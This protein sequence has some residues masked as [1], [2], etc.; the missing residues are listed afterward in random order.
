MLAQK[1][2]QSAHTER[3]TER[4][5]FYL[6]KRQHSPKT[7]G[8]E[9]NSEEYHRNLDNGV[10]EDVANFA[11][12]DIEDGLL[13]GLLWLEVV[14]NDAAETSILLCSLASLI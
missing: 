2:R 1:Y 8:K 10:G 9:D 14:V 13:G 12:D 6:S 3:G 4:N 5:A 7:N 11:K